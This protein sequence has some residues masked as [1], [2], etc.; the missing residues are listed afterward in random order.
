MTPEIALRDQVGVLLR[1][2]SAVTALV[3]KKIRDDVPSDALADKLPWICMGPISVRRVEMG[4]CLPAWA[5]T[6]RVLAES[7]EFNRDEAWTIARA[8]IRALEGAEPPADLG[9]T[10]RLTITNAGDV[11]DPGKIKTVFLDVSC[12]LV[13]VA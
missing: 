6:L 4:N 11:I 2:S 5:I 3:Q 12:T 8:A 13:D 1:A 9:F 7:S 10:D